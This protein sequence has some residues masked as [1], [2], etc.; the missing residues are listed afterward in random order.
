MRTGL[1]EVLAGESVN[2]K[3]IVPLAEPLLDVPN[4]GI[5]GYFPQSL[6]GL[7]GTVAEAMDAISDTATAV[8]A[9]VRNDSL[10]KGALVPCA[11]AAAR[12]QFS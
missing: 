7:S 8:E 9:H 5:Y 12:L 6:A 4:H 1:C 11:L 3:E 10:L 2:D